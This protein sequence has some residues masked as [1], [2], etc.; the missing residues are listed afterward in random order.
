MALFLPGPG[1]VPARSPVSSTV[2]DGARH[3][4]R[5]GIA[6]RTAGRVLRDSPRSV[7]GTFRERAD[8]GPSAETDRLRRVSRSRAVRGGSRDESALSASRHFPAG[9]RPRASCRGARPAA[10]PPAPEPRAVLRPGGRDRTPSLLGCLYR[11]TRSRP[12]NEAAASLEGSRE[13]VTPE[14]SRGRSSSTETST[15]SRSIWMPGRSPFW[16]PIRR[17]GENASS[18]SGTSVPT[19]VCGGCRDFCRARPRNGKGRSCV[20][21]RAGSPTNDSCGTAGPRSCASPVRT[22]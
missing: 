8:V 20:A 21:T 4:I 10:R 17:L 1:V 9:L 18:T 22:G 7:R 15:T 14:R 19:C 16:T 11:E 3:G 2:R 13:G 6:G 5:K 12:R